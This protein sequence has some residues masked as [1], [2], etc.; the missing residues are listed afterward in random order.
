M[1]VSA[2]SD[3]TYTVSGMTCGGCA[4]KVTVAVE[5]IPGVLGV[6]VDLAVGGITLTTDGAVGD[7]AVR[8]AVEQAGYRLATD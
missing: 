8:D 6:D 4:G 7:D 1:S 3:N 5:R 2:S